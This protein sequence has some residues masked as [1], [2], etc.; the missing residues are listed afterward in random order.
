MKNA[1][2]LAEKMSPAIVFVDEIDRFG[3]R[4]GTSAGSAEEE[5][6]ECSLNF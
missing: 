3:K 6:R 4:T 5:T 1:I 2:S